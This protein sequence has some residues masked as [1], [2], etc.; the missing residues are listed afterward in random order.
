MLKSE[1]C[2]KYEFD[3]ARLIPIQTDIESRT[4][5]TITTDSNLSNETY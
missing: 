5:D 1:D 3:L 4:T 2:S